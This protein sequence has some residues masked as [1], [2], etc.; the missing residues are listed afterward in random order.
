M[1]PIS[2]YT[3]R[4]FA[5]ACMKASGLS[6][7]EIAVIINHASTRTATERYGRARTG[8]KR[9]KKMFRIDPWRLALVR[10]KARTHVPKKGR[11][12]INTSAPA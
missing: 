6:R 11:T 4:H 10:N 1:R 9:A 3:L 12:V 5:I 8:T 7:E 2:L